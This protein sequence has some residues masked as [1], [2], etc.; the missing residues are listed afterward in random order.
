MGWYPLLLREEGEGGELRKKK[1]HH[2]PVRSLVRETYW[3]RVWIA[4]H[5]R[6]AGL[7]ESLPPV[8]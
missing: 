3:V 6:T 7:G 8:G 1:F 4:L 2:A 5:Y